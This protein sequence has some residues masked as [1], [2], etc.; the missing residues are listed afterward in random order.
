M[1]RTR[2][3]TTPQSRKPVPALSTWCGR[4]RPGASELIKHDFTTWELLGQWGFQ[5]GASPT[6]PGWHFHD[7]TRTN[8]EILT[9]LYRGIRAAAGERLI[10]S[11]NVVGHLGAGYFEMQRTGDDVSG[12]VWERTRRMGVNTLLFACRRIAHSLPTTQTAL[13]SRRR[14][15]G[16]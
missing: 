3:P 4:R 16:R 12:K 5:M 2:L 6:L 15:H 14:L 10:I 11:C 7:R 13:R 9:D 1:A 8:A